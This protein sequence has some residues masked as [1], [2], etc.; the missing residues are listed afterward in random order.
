MAGRLIDIA[1]PTAGVESVLDLLGDHPVIGQWS[2]MVGTH[3]LVKAVIPAEEV[4]P[5][6]DRLQRRFSGEPGFRVVLVAIE[7]VIPQ[8]AEPPAPDPS[9][10]KKAYR[11]SREELFSEAQDSI[12]ASPVFIAL[13]MLSA[14][15]ASVG[16]LQDNLAVV[17]GAMVMAPLLA[18]NVTLAL[19]TALGDPKLIRDALRANILGVSIALAFSVAAGAVLHVD[20]TVPAVA[21]RTVVGSAD[22]VIA[23]AAGAAGTLA[24]T[25]G[26]PGAVIGVM[27]AVALLPPL[28]TFG[29]LL[30]G[31]HVRLAFG[32]LLLVVVNVVC[33][34]LAGVFTF[35]VQGVRPRNWWEAERARKAS[36]LAMLLWAA[37][38]S[39]LALTLLLAQPT[40]P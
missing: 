10:A 30:G 3:V 6:L 14:V 27:V 40:V 2:D 17:I 18:P 1:V 9:P 39:L 38:L 12:R 21:S 25:S 26:V 11:V 29:L 23:L 4:E 36:R 24:F 8:L 15:V 19:G 32:A 13:T 5:I 31:G 33:V 16:L 35:V 22:L 20:P 37:A 34:N 28:V 7:A